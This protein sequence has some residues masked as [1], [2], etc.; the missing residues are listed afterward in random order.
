VTMSENVTT[1]ERVSYDSLGFVN[2]TNMF[3]IVIRFSLF[4][5][6]RF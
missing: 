3:K 2:T 5:S 6:L 4:Y 1:T